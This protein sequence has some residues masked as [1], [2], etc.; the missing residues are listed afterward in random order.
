MPTSIVKDTNAVEE[1]FRKEVNFKQ[2]LF[3]NT[4]QFKAENPVLLTPLLLTS[5][6]FGTYRLVEL[7]PVAVGL[8]LLN[9][10]VKKHFPR[11]VENDSAQPSLDNICL[12]GGDYFYSRGISI[13]AQVNRSAIIECMSQAIVDITEAQAV[14]DEPLEFENMHDVLRDDGLW[15]KRAAL[16]RAACKLGAILGQAEVEFSESLERFG[17]ICGTMS[18]AVEAIQAGYMDSTGFDDRLVALSEE[19]KKCL[20]NLPEN[21]YKAY[22][23]EVPDR[24]V[25][26][27]KPKV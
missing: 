1:L 19:A 27:A 13:A 3:S 16:H 22:L 4:A 21:E 17:Q 23:I 14:N 11:G 24:L 18:V 7:E 2:G 20:H 6:K 8:E 25:Y 5:A 10:G 9:L 26:I 15:S 12:V